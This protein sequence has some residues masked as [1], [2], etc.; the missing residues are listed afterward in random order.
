M[1]TIFSYFYFYYE[2]CLTIFRYFIWST[3]Q[4]LVRKAIDRVTPPGFSRMNES[5]SCSS[6]IR[7]FAESLIVLALRKLDDPR[8][9][10]F[11]W[12]NWS[13]RTKSSEFGIDWNVEL[14]MKNI[15]ALGY[16]V[17]IVAS[18]NK[19]YSRNLIEYNHLFYL[20]TNIL[21]TKGQIFI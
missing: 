12:S 13:W 4:S 21:L 11:F 16:C 8:M 19:M 20:S 1:R 6:R 7:C 2:I 15:T 3:R 18:I 17:V 10:Y 5:R 9:D 14:F